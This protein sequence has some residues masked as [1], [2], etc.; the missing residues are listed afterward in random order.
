MTVVSRNGPDTLYLVPTWGITGRKAVPTWGLRS[1]T[2]GVNDLPPCP[3]YRIHYITVWRF[4][5]LQKVGLR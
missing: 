3:G 2:R 4:G 1:D 5:S